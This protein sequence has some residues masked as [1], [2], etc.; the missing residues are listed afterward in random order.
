LALIRARNA[1]TTAAGPDEITATT[2]Q[3]LELDAG[4]IG[5]LAEQG[6]RPS[7]D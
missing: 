5:R 6:Q 3:A 1:I 2:A 4:L 7:K